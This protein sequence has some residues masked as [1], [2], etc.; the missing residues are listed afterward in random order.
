MLP[1]LKWAGGKRWFVASHNALLPATYQRYIEPFLGSGTVFFHLEPQTAILGDKNPELITAYTAI[2]DSWA[3]VASALRRH[4]RNHSS[5]YYYRVRESRPRAPHQIAARLVYL[6]R[7]CFNAIYRVNLKGQF[8]VPIGTKTAVI[9]DSDDFKAVAALLSR[10]E[11]VAQDFEK[12]IQLAGADD[13]IFA[14]PPYTV[15]HNNNGFIKY[16]ET[17]F[18]WDD[19]VRL[20]HALKCARDRGAKVIA[21]NANHQSLRKIYKDLG[22]AI[23]TVQRFSSISAGGAAR[24]TFEEIVIMANCQDLTATGK[25]DTHDR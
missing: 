14:D 24:G 13:F 4:H 12:V 21:T 11:L 3:D 10:T 7:T 19:Q 5:S 2:R 17:L 20:A 18:S 23:R 22:F 16:N 15:A 25:R 8:N 9:S 6:N 1:F